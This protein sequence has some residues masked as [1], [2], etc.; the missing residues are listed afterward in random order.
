MKKNMTCLVLIFCLSVFSTKSQIILEDFNDGSVADWDTT[1]GG[2][3]PSL[4]SCA[5]NR[6]D[7]SEQNGEL[8]L[9]YQINDATCYPLM[10]KF[11]TVP[12]DLTSSQILKVRYKTSNLSGTANLRVELGD[13]NF[14]V[15]NG[16]SPDVSPIISDGNYH[17]YY[18]NFNDG[19]S[20]W[21]CGYFPPFP[22]PADWYSID[23]S[24]IQILR[25]IVDYGDTIN[26]HPAGYDSIW[27]DEI[28]MVSSLPDVCTNVTDPNILDNFET[29]RHVNYSKIQGYLVSLDN[30]D[31][32]VVNSTYGIGKLI[33][34][35]I[36]DV[37]AV[38]VGD[39]CDSLILT[40]NNQLKITVF[41]NDFNP[42]TVLVSLQNYDGT[43]RR[44][45]G[46]PQVASTTKVNDWEDLIFDFKS[47]TDSVSVNSFVII[48]NPGF[49]VFDSLYIDNIRI[50]G[51]VNPNGIKEKDEV[52]SQMNIYPNPFF[53]K[54]QLSYN[55]K[56]QGDIKIKIVDVLGRE[57]VNLFNENQTIGKHQ[58]N[59]QPTNID[60]GVYF[61]VITIDERLVK[62]EKL[63]YIK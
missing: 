52:I 21:R 50:E 44:E 13:G 45:V 42:K 24:Q 48:L 40:S 38:L 49:A 41:N 58:I 53:D 17:D 37:N 26:N 60:G 15:T 62:T 33:K 11:L 56:E 14:Y 55:L 35:G 16:F 61:C 19:F 22:T 57:V 1:G 20:K 9:Y 31:T 12:V 6:F 30:I 59:W 25:I 39:L 10:T 32:T 51:F 2:N 27:I 47:I 29:E 8:R 3:Y 23:S 28:S 5:G 36:S 46:N 63:I 7:F 34:D 4:G 43:N 18:F 54:I